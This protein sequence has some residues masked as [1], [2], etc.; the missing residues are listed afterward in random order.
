MPRIARKDLNSN[1]L[2][3]M[4]QGINKEYIFDSFQNKNKYKRI[5]LENIKNFKFAEL[6][7]LSYCFMDNHS[8]FLFYC[9]NFPTLSKFMQLTNSRYSRY[10]NKINNRV[11]Y[12]FRDRFKVQQIMDIDQLYNCLKY[13]H[14]NPVK[15]C[16]CNEMSNYYFSSFNEFTGKVPR[17]L[18]NEKSIKL[19]FGNT[20]DF[21]QQFNMIHKNFNSEDFLD[22]K[23]VNISDFT[24]LFLRNFSISLDEIKKNKIVMKEFI[25]EARKQTDVTQTELA[26]ILGISKS[27]VSLYL[28]N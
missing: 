16:I 23:E 21:L 9:D 17:T 10:Y 8:H 1:F 27:T 2:H 28:K 24:R 26:N 6:C 19:L 18:I 12:V 5:I 25:K 20:N 14:N 11:G 15:A 3:V 4:V 13:I 7:I 22:I